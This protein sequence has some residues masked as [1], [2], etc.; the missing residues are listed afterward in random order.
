MIYGLLELVFICLIID[1]LRASQAQMT[2]SRYKFT[3]KDCSL[4]IDI[5]PN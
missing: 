4:K 3:N 2:T 1:Y 5:V